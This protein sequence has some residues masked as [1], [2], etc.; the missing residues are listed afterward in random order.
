MS[1]Q[2]RLLL[3]GILAFFVATLGFPVLVVAQP[4]KTPSAS[5]TADARRHFD[6]GLK[7]FQDRVYEAALVEFEQSYALGRR[8]SALRNVAQSQ[9]ELKRF[10][11]AHATY[12]SL[13]ARHALEI[14]PEERAE[15]SRAM[16]DLQLVT[17]LVELTTAEGAT[18]SVDG[19]AKGTAPLASP[20]RLDVGSHRARVE[21]QGQVA[22][23]RDFVI[24]AQQTVR[25]AVDLAAEVRTGTVRV[26][27]RTNHVVRVLVDGNDVGPAPWEGQLPAGKHQIEAR[28]SRLEAP[29]QTIEVVS[30][31]VVE[32][33]VDAIPMETRLRIS[34]LPTSA[35][36]LVDGN[37]VWSLRP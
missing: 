10:A 32:L 11:A 17:G 5:E 7:L 18:V 3:S 23:E 21:K 19:A 16:T 34:V 1:Q 24:L 14:T 28:G 13:L 35:N 6:A 2:L 20:M 9:R 36:I 33:V 25:V 15:Y 12:E 22:R 4:A 31:A 37:H 27:E 29:K 26:R 8:P 30:G